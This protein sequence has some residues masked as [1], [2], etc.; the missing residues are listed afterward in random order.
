MNISIHRIVGIK[1]T[2][3]LLNGLDILILEIVDREGWTTEL[4]LF[5]LN[6][7]APTITVMADEDCHPIPVGE[8]TEVA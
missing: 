5:G 6:N 3:R 2:K 8:V 1:Q 7:A 4:N